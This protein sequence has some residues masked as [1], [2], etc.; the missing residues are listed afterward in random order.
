MKRKKEQLVG[1][2]V[3]DRRQSVV[4]MSK[5]KLEEKELPSKGKGRKGA[6]EI[7]DVLSS[8]LEA[9]LKA[10]NSDYIDISLYHGVVDEK[11]L[12]HPEV[13]NFFTEMKKSGVIK[14]C[15]TSPV[16]MRS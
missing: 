4:I 8:K 3:A 12:Y 14:A 16:N 10:L 7:R 15:V 2:A 5:M 1:R 6:S 9:S 11:L 13:I